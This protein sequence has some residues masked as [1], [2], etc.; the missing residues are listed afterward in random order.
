MA[1]PDRLHCC[2][3]S[4]HIHVFLL[5]DR[6]LIR[7]LKHLARHKFTESLERASFPT[8]FPRVVREVYAMTTAHHR[9]LRKAV[10][11]FTVEVLRCET[12]RGHFDFNFPRHILEEIP[13]FTQDLT[14]KLVD[15]WVEDE[16]HRGVDLMQLAESFRLC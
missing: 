9:L 1:T 16:K 5:A 3:L 4:I 12:E 10:V 2:E 15:E 6:L 7:G 8:V 11:N 14:T 13:E